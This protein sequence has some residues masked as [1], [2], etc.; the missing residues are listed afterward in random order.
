MNDKH[1]EVYRTGNIEPN[2][3]ILNF[4]YKKHHHYPIINEKILNYLLNSNV[5]KYSNIS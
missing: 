4:E 1:R 3:N 5:C 2:N